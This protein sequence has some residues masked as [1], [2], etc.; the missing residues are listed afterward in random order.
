MAKKPTKRYW[1]DWENA[2]TRVGQSA[3]DGWSLGDEPPQRRFT[4][5][6]YE[7]S[8]SAPEIV[9]EPPP[10]PPSEPVAAVAPPAHVR[11][12]TARP[13]HSEVAAAQ[14]RAGS[15]AEHL[16]NRTTQP[17]RQQSPPPE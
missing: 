10:E 6:G 2:A 7:A 17:R 12:P 8:E 4:Q 15:F 14:T 3:D 1:V 16:E 5:R 13:S 11:S 9:S